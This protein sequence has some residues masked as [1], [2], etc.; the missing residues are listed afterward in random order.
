H[1]PR[2][3][4]YLQDTVEMAVNGVWEGIKHNLSLTADAGPVNQ[5]DG[6]DLPAHTLDR[7]DSPLVIEILPDAAA[8]SERQMIENIYGVDMSKCKVQVFE[9]R[10]PMNDKTYAGR[11]KA[12]LNLQ[13]GLRFWLGFMI[14]DNDQ[15]GTDLQNLLVWPCTYGTTTP[16][17]PHGLA[18]LE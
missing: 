8:V 16:K 7:G 1:Q 2:C 5:V 18:V 4:A 17:E 3:R 12:R 11:E 15:P 9:T 6:W 13:P 10:I 14:D